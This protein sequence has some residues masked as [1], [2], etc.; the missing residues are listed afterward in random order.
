MDKIDNLDVQGPL[1]V[2]IFILNNP[3]RLRLDSAHRV[4]R[5][6]RMIEVEFH[7][8]SGTYDN[9][10]NLSNKVLTVHP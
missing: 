9:S 6:I 2:R 4:V 7:S 5:I 3:T 8:V 10:Y 1:Q